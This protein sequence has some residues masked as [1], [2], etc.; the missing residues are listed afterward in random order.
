MIIYSQNAK[1]D[2]IKSE[3][4]I[5]GQCRHVGVNQIQKQGISFLREVDV[6]MPIFVWILTTYNQFRQ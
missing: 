6:Q 2:I 4:Y 5:I 1:L 3:F